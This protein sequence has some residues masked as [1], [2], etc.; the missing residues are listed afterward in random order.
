MANPLML[1][2]EV[3]VLVVVRKAQLYTD[4]NKDG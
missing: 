4:Y 3:F 2:W 1:N